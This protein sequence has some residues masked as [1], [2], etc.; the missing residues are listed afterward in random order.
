MLLDGYLICKDKQEPWGDQIYVKVDGKKVAG[1]W[2]KMKEGKVRHLTTPVEGKF[3]IEVWE[4]DKGRDD[5]IGSRTLI[6]EDLV[7][8]GQQSTDF[9]GR[10]AHYALLYSIS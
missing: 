8:K 4:Q 9:K 1:T 3:S 5:F 10:G 7:G 2:K 6:A